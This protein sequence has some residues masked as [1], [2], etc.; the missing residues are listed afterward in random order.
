MHSVVDSLPYSS[1]SG[2][3]CG[4]QKSSGYIIIVAV[5]GAAD[6]AYFGKMATGGQVSW[7]GDDYHL[8]THSVKRT[9][10]AHFAA[11]E[12]VSQVADSAFGCTRC[13]AVGD[14][15]RLRVVGIAE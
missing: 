4:T 9:A 11:A 2:L 1:I 5:S 3:H 7:P 8:A 10:G 15:L 6:V 14:M 13:F 12:M